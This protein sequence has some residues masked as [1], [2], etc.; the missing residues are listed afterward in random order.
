MSS[1]TELLAELDG[2]LGD[3]QAGQLD[4]RPRDENDANEVQAFFLQVSLVIVFVFILASV[5]FHSTSQ[6]EIERLKD[7]LAGV[8]P[9]KPVPEKVQVEAAMTEVQL[10]K[11]LQALDKVEIEERERLA[12]A[13][14]AP[15]IDERVVYNVNGVLTGG[16]VSTDATGQRFQKGCQYAVGKYTN[17]TSL[18]QDWLQRVLAKAEMT[19]ESSTTHEDISERPNVVV[20]NNKLKLFQLIRERTQAIRGEMR[21]VQQLA[22]GALFDF[23]SEHPEQIQDANLS[24]LMARFASLVDRNVA[25]AERDDVARQVEPALTTYART[26][27]QN[28][29]APL[30]P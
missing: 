25:P 12:L 11:L 8:L 22:L 3:G 29:G 6:A 28:C 5:L 17:Q 9:P 15:K 27:F 14:F 1:E 7:E 4:P 30:L 21:T 26:V 13:V 16:Q 19:F 2:I 23:Y 24:Q 20:G 10:L 18:L